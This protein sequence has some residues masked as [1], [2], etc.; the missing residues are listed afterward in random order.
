MSDRPLKIALFSNRKA[1][2]TDFYLCFFVNKHFYFSGNPGHFFESSAWLKRQ[3]F[4][5]S[6]SSNYYLRIKRSEIAGFVCMF[7]LW[8]NLIFRHHQTIF[9]ISSAFGWSLVCV[10]SVICKVRLL[11][12]DAF[13]R[14]NALLLVDEISVL[15]HH[16]VFFDYFSKLLKMSNSQSI[17]KNLKHISQLAQFFMFLNLQRFN[18]II[19]Y[20]D[21]SH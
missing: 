18:A 17:I 12:L 9:K 7:Y 2:I 13:F 19:S 6:E 5:R 10:C 8:K 21:Q 15:C 20:L 14:A 4:S 3:S 11:V 16:Q 1:A